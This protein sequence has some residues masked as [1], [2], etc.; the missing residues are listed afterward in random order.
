MIVGSDSSE[1]RRPP[2][3]ARW[4][5]SRIADHQ[6]G[7][8]FLVGVVD[9]RGDQATAPQR[10]RP[11]DVDAGAGQEAI[12]LPEAVQLRDLAQRERGSLEEEHR[13]QEPLG[14]RPLAVRLLEP[15]ERP[16]QVDCLGQVVVRD[17]ALG[18]RHGGGDRLAHLRRIEARARCPLHRGRYRAAAGGRLD[19]GERNCAIRARA[20]DAT[21]AKAEL[22]RAPARGGRHADP[23]ATL[24]SGSGISTGGWAGEGGISGGTSSGGR[25]GGGW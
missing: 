18:A 8:R 3:R 11:A 22:C 14:R 16:A 24:A 19:I 25:S 4:T 15:G 20:S 9:G 6:L 21:R 1:L 12:L 7:E 5:R 17:L 13:G 2:A 23:D 10:N